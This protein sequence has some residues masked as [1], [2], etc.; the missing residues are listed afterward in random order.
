VLLLC[1]LL[2]CPS[3]SFRSPA[4]TI[5]TPM[6]ALVA[7]L[8]ADFRELLA[9]FSENPVSSHVV[10]PP[11]NRHSYGE[12]RAQWIGINDDLQ[13][14]NKRPPGSPGDLPKGLSI[15]HPYAD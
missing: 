15:G 8:D 13:L 2:F 6:V 9:N 14:V 1:P 5:I 7:K 4:S 10:V 3:Y 12:V 11:A